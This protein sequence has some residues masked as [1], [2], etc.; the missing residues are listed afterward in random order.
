[1]HPELESRGLSA[2]S[3]VFAIVMIALVCYLTFA[4]LQGEYGLFRLF[5]IE[6]QETRLEAELAALQTQRAAI[7]NKTERLSVDHLDLELLDEQ[8][9]KVLGLARADE[10]IIR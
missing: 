8:A 3:A 1:M 5:Q 9:R 6:A 2:G 4:A 7:E 10:I